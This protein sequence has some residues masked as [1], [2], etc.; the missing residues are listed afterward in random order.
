MSFSKLG[1]EI[2][3][4]YETDGLPASGAHKIVK[5][6]MR[7][8]MLQ[9]EGQG[10]SSLGDGSAATPVLA[11]SADPDTGIYRVGTNT[12]GIAAGGARVASFAS[13]GMQLGVAGALLGA[14]ILAGS[15]SG[16]TTLQPN[17]AA[18]GTLTLP[19]ATDTLVG[20]ATTDTLTNKTLT[21]PSINTPTIA[22][23]THTA[24]TSLGIRSTGSGAFDLTFANTENLTAGRTLTI[25]TGDAARSLTLVADATIGRT[26]TGTANEITVTNGSGAA[27]NPT[28]SL[29]NALTFTGKT[30]TGGTFA[31]PTAITGLPD[32]TNAQDA[33]TKAYVDSL[34][35]GLDV[36]PSVKCATTA[37]ITLSGAQTIDG[38]SAGI[39]D[40]VLVKNQSTAS[41][42]GVYVVAS[43]SWTRATDMDAWAEVPGSFVFVE[44]GTTFADCAFVCT[45]DTGGTLGSTSITWSQFAGAGT[46]TASTGLTL[47]GTQFS[48]DSSTV[49]TLTGS[50]TLTNKTLTAPVIATISNTGTL[51]LPTATDTLVGRAT[52][53]TLTN[54]TLSAAVAAGTWTA[55]GTW[56]IPAVTLGGAVSGNGQSITALLNVGL[57]GYLDLAEIATPANPAANVARLYSKD[58]GGGT[59]KLYFR[60]SSGA[61]TEIG[62]GGG[63]GGVTTTYPISGTTALVSKAP[64]ACGRLAYSSATALTFTPYNGDL[65]KISGTLYQIPSAGIT[66]LANTSVY[67][68]GVSGQNL[69]ANTL[70]Y[71]YVFNNGGTLT[72]DFSTTARATSSTSGNIGTEIKSG[73]DSRTLIGLIRTNASS[74]FADS[75]TQRFVQSWFNRKPLAARNA[76]TANRTT[77]SSS[78]VEL[79]TE[80]RIEFVCWSDQVVTA[81]VNGPAYINSASQDY[82]FTSV[83]FDGTTN[84]D[85]AAAYSNNVYGIVN[86]GY[87]YNKAGLSE[88]YH[89]ATVLGKNN[90]GSLTATYGDGT[91]KFMTMNLII[92]S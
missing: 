51:T 56:T 49:T 50:Q 34:S 57:T 35:A 24:L 70:Y 80:I 55:S 10:V 90:A 83:G 33:A 8:W 32:P 89:Y 46:Y 72:A 37:N 9:V 39:G 27:G 71:V 76:F 52:T 88:G 18:S 11:F 86:A 1:A 78:Y 2:F 26:I 21:S 42:N 60:D 4:D 59:T 62:T 29:P 44:Q 12:L 25:V 23:G 48:I 58:D 15:T 75:A 41:Q 73:D 19:A 79:N 28:L 82:I 84:N 65:I 5:A 47:T 85:F 14:L 77:T 69:A 43:G 16:T 74:Q 68:N 67:V 45:A 38:V 81:S 54:K 40:R 31:S 20:R 64:Q 61:E 66:G 92:R 30:I 53:D 63:G 22:G 36:K 17:V 87:T 91:G 3:R 13:A 7:D 6:D